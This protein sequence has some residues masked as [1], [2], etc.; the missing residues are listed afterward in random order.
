LLFINKNCLGVVPP[1]L[2]PDPPAT[3]TAYLFMLQ[4]TM[5]SLK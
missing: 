3:I 4:I 1:I 5:I 2:V